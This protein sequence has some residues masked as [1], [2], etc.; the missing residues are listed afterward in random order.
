MNKVIDLDVKRYLGSDDFFDYSKI[1]LQEP[2]EA[3][4]NNWTPNIIKSSVTKSTSEYLVGF[5]TQ[6]E[7]YCVCCVDMVDSTKI[8][9]QLG[10]KKSS[11]YYQVFLNSM[12]RIIT[13]FGGEVIKNIGDCLLYY[14]PS[15][16]NA[17]KNTDFVNCIEGNFAMLEAQGIISEMLKKEGLPKLNYRISADY[18]VVSLM[19]Q[20]NSEEMDLIGPPVNIVS[21]INRMAIKN[22]MVVGGDFHEIVKGLSDYCFREVK[23][24]SSGLKFDYPVYSVSRKQSVYQ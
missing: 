17:N 5:L 13:R 12:S 3:I 15:T 6:T 11:R 18:G 9:A 24:C 16:K 8:S 1:P 23:A 2:V 22:G 14:F 4:V 20:S 7:S 21:K 19:K 10:L